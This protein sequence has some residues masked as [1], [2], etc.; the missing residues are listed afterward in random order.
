MTENII[1]IREYDVP[2]YL[3]VAIDRDVRVGHWY[4]VKATHG[5]ATMS[6]QYNKLER[7]ETVVLGSSPFRARPLPHRPVPLPGSPPYPPA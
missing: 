5:H 6:R 1:D 7:A 3:R 2:Y 4:T